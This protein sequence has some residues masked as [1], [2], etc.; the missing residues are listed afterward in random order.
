MTENGLL[1]HLPM[2][3]C[4]TGSVLPAGFFS[5]SAL[6]YTDFFLRR[7]WHEKAPVCLTLAA[8]I[9]DTRNIR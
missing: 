1:S 5:F 4:A 6:D 2:C 3:V 9:H 8:A 7:Y